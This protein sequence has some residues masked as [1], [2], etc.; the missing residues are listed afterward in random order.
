MVSFI[1]GSI[2]IMGS[3]FNTVVSIFKQ[4]FTI[5][6]GDIHVIN[7]KNSTIMFFCY[8]TDVLILRLCVFHVQV[9]RGEHTGTPIFTP[10]STINR[11]FD[12]IYPCA[13]RTTSVKLE[14]ISANGRSRFH[15]STTAISCFTDDIPQY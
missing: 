10:F 6:R 13:P 12:Q 11:R 3:I 7:N 8:Y 4:F 1:V 15:G 2:H 9:V 5:F 14:L